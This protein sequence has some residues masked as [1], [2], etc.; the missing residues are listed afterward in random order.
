MRNFH[1]LTVVKERGVYTL[2]SVGPDF[3]PHLYSYGKCCI[4]LWLQLSSE[5]SFTCMWPVCVHLLY[6]RIESATNVVYTGGVGGRIVYGLISKS[7]QAKTLVWDELKIW[8][9]ITISAI[10]WLLCVFV[11]FCF[12]FLCW[13]GLTEVLIFVSDLVILTFQVLR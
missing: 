12:F 5:G 3:Q 1:V 13:I 8:P 9:Y 7:T 2:G 6:K 10:L 11:G 4:Q